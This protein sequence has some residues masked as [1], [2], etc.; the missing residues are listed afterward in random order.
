MVNWP[1][2]TYQKKDFP[3]S[4]IR[5]YLEPGPIVLVSSFYKN[6]TD[7]MTMGWHTVMEFSPSLIGCM[8]SEGNHSFE[9]IKK[10]KECVIN[11]PEVHL[12]QTVV[13]I[14][15]C[16]GSEVEKFEEFSFTPLKAKKVD[17]PL[18]K[19]CFANFEC[20]VVDVSLLKKFNFFVMEVVK[21][22]VPSTPKYPRTIH[23]RGEGQ[24]M[25]SGKSLNL[26]SKFLPQNL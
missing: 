23:Y 11:L 15:N 1:M 2:K 8:I 5:R 4:Q 10:S 19:E 6:E 17:A 7:I 18:I 24:F 13:G 25:I 20:K 26:K 14:G 12:A 3:V 16:S 22:H 9:L 21:A